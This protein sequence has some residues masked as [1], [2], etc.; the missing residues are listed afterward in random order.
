MM[1]KRCQTDSLSNPMM[2]AFHTVQTDI[3]RRIS[4]GEWSV[5]TMLPGRHA[6]AKSY[7]VALN[8]L[9]RAL[10][11][12]FKE[13]ILKALPGRGTFVERVP[14][15]PSMREDR[16]E[17]RTPPVLAILTPVVKSSSQG[18]HNDN[19]AVIC[20]QAVEQAFSRLGGCCRYYKINVPWESENAEEL[21]KAVGKAVGDGADALV[22]NNI[23][24]NRFW[25]EDAETLASMELPPCVYVS[26]IPTVSG[27]PTVCG[28]LYY[29]G[30]QAAEHLTAVGYSTI[31]V[32]VP[33][34][35][36]WLKQRTEGVLSVAE[37]AV[38]SDEPVPN[39]PRYLSLDAGERQACIDHKVEELLEKMNKRN[40]D[41]RPCAIVAPNDQ[42][43]CLVKNSFERQRIRCGSEVGLIAFDGSSASRDAGLTTLCPPLEHLGEM[44]SRTVAD[45][46]AGRHAP[47]QS[48]YTSHLAARDST[49]LSS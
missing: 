26:T 17:N 35:A 32:L 24:G 18:S 9:Q 46:L 28:D 1:K 34:H 36:E 10:E 11:E 31:G 33:F 48:R 15:R 7:G 42:I 19:W 41:Q 14:P 43:A 13:G 39:W 23:Y 4:E 16:T 40:K 8:T 44:T 38:L 27:L 2:P 25:A 6:L 12:L 20:T 22:V 30:R 5:G 3:R 45:I 47:L 49:Y 37:D 29:D 21:F